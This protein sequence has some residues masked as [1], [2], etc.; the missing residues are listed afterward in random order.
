MA[1][2]DEIAS[3]NLLITHYSSI[4]FDYVY[5]D[6]P[7]I[8]TQFDKETFYS[9]HAY[10]RGYFDYE[11]MGFGPVCYDYES[12]VQCIIAAIEGGCVM[13][14][15][16][17]KRVDEFFAYHDGKNCERIYNEILKLKKD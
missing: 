15:Q 3:T 10:K 1:L 12:T 8:Y 4:A 16:Y 13:G 9:D 17:K 7:V 2:E 5:A 6:I 14:E 11:T